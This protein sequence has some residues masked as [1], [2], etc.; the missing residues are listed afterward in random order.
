LPVSD[1]KS[2]ILRRLY[3]EVINTLALDI[4]LVSSIGKESFLYNSLRVYGE[5]NINDIKNA[6]FLLYAPEIDLKPNIKNKLSLE[7]ITSRFEDAALSFGLKYSIKLTDK[8]VAKAMVNNSTKQVLLN[9]HDS[10]NTHELESLVHHELGVHALTTENAEKQLLSIFKLGLPGNT[11]TQEGLAIYNEYLSGN[12]TLDRLK[13]LALR[14]IAIDHMLR[15]QNFRKTYNY[16][17]NMSNLDED[18]CFRLI[19]RVY[20]GGG[21]TKDYLYLS[22]L[23]DIIKSVKEKDFNLLFIGKTSLKFIPTLK[24]LYQNGWIS[25]PYKIPETYQLIK[26]PP[27]NNLINYLI[28]SIR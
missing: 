2:P 13:E 3:R 24:E 23:R 19:T 28:K 21:F 5:P 16:I 1:I 22:G 11:H 20:R 26:K 25:K 15:H 14:V 10:L 17:K 6:Q 12:L 4:D 18:S 9:K 8:I 27:N 7:E